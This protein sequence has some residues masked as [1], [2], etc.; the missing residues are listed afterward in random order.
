M[1]Y[2]PFGTTD[3]QVSALGFGAMRLPQRSADPADIDEVEAI[4]MIRTAIDAGVNYVDT[5]YPYHGGRSEVAVGKALRDGYRPG[6]GWRP[7]CRHGSS[8]LPRTSTD[9]SASSLSGWGRTVLT[10]ISCTRSMRATG[11]V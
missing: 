2:R 4:R 3:F 9:S 10:S 11:H 7:S 8:R 5:A 6:S 1:R